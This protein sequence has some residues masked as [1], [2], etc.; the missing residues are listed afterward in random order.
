MEHSVL[1][2]YLVLIYIY[3][4][5]ILQVRARGARTIIITDRV[6]LADN[7]AAPA[8]VLLIPSCGTLTSLVALQPIEMMARELKASSV[9]NGVS[10]YAY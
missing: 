3:I 1:P 7:L 4:D 8:D 5:A 9:K 2:C 10:V 6:D